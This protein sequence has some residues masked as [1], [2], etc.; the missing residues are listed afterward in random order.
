MRACARARVYV[1]VWGVDA[2]VRACV[3]VRVCSCVCMRV[4]VSVCARA[5]ARACVYVC[6]RVC[7]RA[8][9][10]VCVCVCARA[11]GVG[12]GGGRKEEKLPQLGSTSDAHPTKTVSK[13]KQ[14]MSQWLLMFFIILST[15][16]QS[17]DTVWGGG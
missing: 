16:V 10:C 13:C 8:R 14:V 4:C 7:A 11:R 17:K 3:Y 9:V 12:E 5:R 6:V 1:C 2:C 15:S